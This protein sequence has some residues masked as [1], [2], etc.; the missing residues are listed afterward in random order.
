M[1]FAVL[2]EEIEIQSTFSRGEGLQC[3]RRSSTKMRYV[4]R[5]AH[6]ETVGVSFA[7]LSE[8]IGM[9]S[10]FSRG[11]GVQRVRRSPAKMRYAPKIPLKN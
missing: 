10:T 7:V 4:S 8:K 9:Q 5:N 3:V 6:G 1:F 2:S 11:E